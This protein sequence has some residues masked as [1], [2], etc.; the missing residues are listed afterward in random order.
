[1]NVKTI[2]RMLLAFSAVMIYIAMTMD[3]TVSSGYGYVHNIGLQS[4]QTN[5]LILGGIGFIAGIILF[6]TSKV[7]QTKQEE[8]DEKAAIDAK[9]HQVATT[10]KAALNSKGS[11]LQNWWK[12]LDNV[13][14]RVITFILVGC[15]SS[16]LL[17]GCY[18]GV[19]NGLFLLDHYGSYIFSLLFISIGFK[20][21]TVRPATKV[22]MNLISVNIV[23]WIMLVV[24]SL[25]MS[26]I[27]DGQDSFSII[28]VSLIFIFILTV[29]KWL[30][31]RSKNKTVS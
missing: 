7:K 19:F 2:S 11:A 27:K 24:T 10:A 13:V 22:I 21:F 5:M 8:E 15:L 14:G 6:S 23:L 30:I 1:M 29:T 9:I 18:L 16:G 28:L 31:K 3:T 12:N 20:I 26:L 17:L 4:E 25:I